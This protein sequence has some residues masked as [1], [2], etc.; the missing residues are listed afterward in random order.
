MR[1]FSESIIVSWDFHLMRWFRHL[2]SRSKIISRVDFIS[3]PQ[4][5]MRRYFTITWGGFKIPMTN[6]FYNNLMRWYYIISWDYFCFITWDDVKSFHE[7]ILI[8]LISRFIESSH[9]II[10]RFSWDERIS[11]HQSIHISSHE[12]KKIVSW[13]NT[14]SS[15]ESIIENVSRDYT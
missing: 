6:F 13:D 4:H 10:N 5:L 12:M 8:R 11:S 15:Y 1:W 9:E 2:M 3:S 14:F 7:I